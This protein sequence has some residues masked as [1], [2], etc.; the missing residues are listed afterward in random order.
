MQQNDALRKIN[1]LL[2][3]ANHPNTDPAEADSAR[4]MANR[5]MLK[6]QIDE[7]MA[8]KGKASQELVPEWLI[9]PYC[10]IGNE[11]LNQYRLLTTV[12]AHH[13]GNLRT[14]TNYSEGNG[15]VEVVGYP[16]DLAF[17]QALFTD[18]KL[19]FS[20]LLE[21]KYNPHKSD[22]ENA[23]V[24][25]AAGM[26]RRRI[27]DAIWGPLP[28]GYTQN[29]L[30]ARTRKVTAL[31][32]QWAADNDLDIAGLFGQANSSMATYRST[33][34]ESFVT[35]LWSR[36]YRY[37]ATA[38]EEAGEAGAIVLRSRK[39]NVD[40]AFYTR[41]PSMR[42][43]DAP[44][45]EYKAPN[46][47]CEKCAKAKSGYCREHAWLKPSTAQAKEQPHSYAAAQRGRSA[48]HDVNLGARGQGR[49]NPAPSRPQVGR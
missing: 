48:A 12:V 44:M 21:P 14:R 34:A 42:P 25:R 37:R 11:F 6:Y 7:A 47:D 27:A 41:Y 23:Y 15:V 45:P 39:E 28:V 9:M 16:S 4:E 5:L 30:K 32:K 17:F 49:A 26:E 10:E 22:A 19:A 1:A 35:E 38:A 40:E 36:A 24:M 33:Y 18:A 31:A 13:V 29:A 2:D 46:A 43:S 3:R 8:A 20:N